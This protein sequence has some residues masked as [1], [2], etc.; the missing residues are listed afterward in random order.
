MCTLLSSVARG[1]DRRK[2]SMAFRQVHGAAPQFEIGGFA[3]PEMLN[4]DNGLAD[5]HAVNCGKQVHPYEKS[6]NPGQNLLRPGRGGES[7]VG[8]LLPVRSNHRIQGRLIVGWQCGLACRRRRKGSHCGN[9]GIDLA[10]KQMFTVAQ[11]KPIYTVC[12]P[13]VPVTNRQLV[14]G[15]NQRQL[16]I[17]ACTL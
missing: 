15:F 17:A 16:E 12:R 9:Q 7:D 2:A 8:C 13:A 6:P 5:L 11:I 1:A 14:V 3:S 10:F 4:G